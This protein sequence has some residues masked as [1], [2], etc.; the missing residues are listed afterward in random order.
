METEAARVVDGFLSLLYSVG[1]SQER[2]AARLVYSFMHGIVLD[3][4]DFVLGDEVFRKA[5]ALKLSV[6]AI[7][8]LL[9]ATLPIKERLPARRG[10]VLRAIFATWH[11]WGFRAAREVARYR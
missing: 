7:D 2:A 4:R 10:F 9:M 8:S 11:Y 5:Q 3:R 1:D 6:P